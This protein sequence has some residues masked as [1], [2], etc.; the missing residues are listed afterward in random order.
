MTQPS[1]E[2]I[3]QCIIKAMNEAGIKR[4]MLITSVHTAQEPL[5]MTGQNVLQ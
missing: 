2:G 1:V 5:L 3:S 4:K